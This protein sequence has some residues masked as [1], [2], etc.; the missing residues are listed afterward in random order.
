MIRQPMDVQK[1]RACRNLSSCVR[2]VGVNAQGR[3]SK[4][5]SRACATPRRSEPAIGCADEDR[6]GQGLPLDGLDDLALRA[7]DIRDQH[8]RTGGLCRS[9]HVL[10]DAIDRRANDDDVGR[11][12]SLAEVG[13]SAVDGA[14]THRFLDGRRVAPHADDLGREMAGS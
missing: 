10:G 2:G 12:D 11:R 7:A 1:R 14:Q 5:S 13:R 6:T 9:A 8:V 3:P 4:R